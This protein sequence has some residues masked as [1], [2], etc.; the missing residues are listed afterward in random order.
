MNV[1]RLAWVAAAAAVLATAPPAAHAAAPPRPAASAATSPFDARI[2][3]AK[4]AMMADPRSALREAQAALKL[5][6]AGP[7][8]AAQSQRVAT[9]QWLQ[10]E[11][12][13]RLNRLDEA[14]PAIREGLIAVET[15]PDTKLHGDLVMAEA[16]LL[17]TQGK[18]QPALQGLQRAYHIFGKAKQPRSQAIALHNIGS[19]YQDARDYA[20]VLQYYAQA[21]EL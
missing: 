10:G 3:A 8:G 20:K 6:K 4:A 2:D 16:G 15:S 5:A 21:A 14:A 1:R 17:A 7:A 19:I 9:A 18:V 13:L 11:A 12:L